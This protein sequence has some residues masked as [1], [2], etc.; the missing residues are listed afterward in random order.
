MDQMRPP[1]NH[2]YQGVQQLTYR[3]K[4]QEKREVKIYLCEG[5][6]IICLIN[7]DTFKEEKIKELQV[8]LIPKNCCFKCKASYKLLDH[9]D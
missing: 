6:K 9:I 4:T 8:V 7:Q 5:E 3:F 1:S 2:N